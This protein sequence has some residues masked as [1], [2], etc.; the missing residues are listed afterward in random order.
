VSQ[1]SESQA[2]GRLS[3][4]GGVSQAGAA[5]PGVDSDAEVVSQAQLFLSED[6]R[7][8]NVDTW[9]AAAML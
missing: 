7:F 8:M 5:G 4:A 6:S 2:L 3:Q 1:G 9:R